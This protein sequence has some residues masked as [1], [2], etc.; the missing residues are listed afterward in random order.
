M[1]QKW[2]VLALILPLPKLRLTLIQPAEA[3]DEIPGTARAVLS[4]VASPTI[5]VSH[6]HYKK[7]VA[8]FHSATHGSHIAVFPVLENL[9]VL[10]TPRVHPLLLTHS[11]AEHHQVLFGNRSRDLA[12]LVPCLPISDVLLPLLS[13]SDVPHIACLNAKGHLA[14]VLKGYYLTAANIRKEAGRRRKVALAQ[15]LLPKTDPC[16]RPLSQ[17]ILP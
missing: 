14:A 5:A 13:F 12:P 6:L 7:P 16:T 15:T 17:P 11:P 1:K 4:Q 2:G 9:K 3:G 8:Q 10:H